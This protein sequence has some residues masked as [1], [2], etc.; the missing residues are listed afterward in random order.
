MDKGAW[1]ATVHGVEKSRPQLKRLSILT[2]G[3]QLMKQLFQSEET[4]F[5]ELC[6]PKVQHRTW[7][8]VIA[9]R[10]VE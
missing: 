1:L 7:Y 5:H 9:A 6:F 8:I 10:I 4:T 3:V 2:L